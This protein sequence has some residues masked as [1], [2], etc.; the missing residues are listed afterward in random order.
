MRR[1]PKP[2]PKQCWLI[3]DWKKAYKFLSVWIAALIGSSAALYEYLPTVR[4]LIGETA[5]HHAMVALAFL[6]IVARVVNQG[7]QK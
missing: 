2:K 5:F 7:V 1:K 6:G 3:T 4:E